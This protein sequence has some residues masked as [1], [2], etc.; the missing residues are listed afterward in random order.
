[1]AFAHDVLKSA[2]A[3]KFEASAFPEHPRCPIQR[4]GADLNFS[5]QV[6][7][8][9]TIVAEEHEIAVAAKQL[10]VGERYQ[11]KHILAIRLRESYFVKA[12]QHICPLCGCGPCGGRARN[13]QGDASGLF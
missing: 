12:I 4:K 10:T 2:S 5:G 13:P 9:L 3:N 6:V 11:R 8:T 1:M 7:S